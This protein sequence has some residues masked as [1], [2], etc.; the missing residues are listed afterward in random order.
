MDWAALQNLLGGPF[1]ADCVYNGLALGQE[2]H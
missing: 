2:M 1:F